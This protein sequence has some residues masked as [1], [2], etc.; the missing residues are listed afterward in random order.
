MNL[1]VAGD[2]TLQGE[3]TTGWGFKVGTAATKGATGQRSSSAQPPR[4]PG[5]SGLLAVSDPWC[6]VLRYHAEGKGSGDWY[7]P[8]APKESQGLQMAHEVRKGLLVVFPPVAEG[9]GE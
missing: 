7:Q 6:L 1:E 9:P 2:A 5:R 4:E 8:G 3:V